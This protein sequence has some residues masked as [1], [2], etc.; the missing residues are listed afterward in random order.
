M[1]LGLPEK[2]CAPGRGLRLLTGRLG[3]GTCTCAGIDT[4]TDTGAGAGPGAGTGAGTDT[5][6]GSPSGSQSSDGVLGS[7]S[8]MCCVSIPP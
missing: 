2:M 8:Q 3:G 5:W 7:G 1:L 4:G 6:V